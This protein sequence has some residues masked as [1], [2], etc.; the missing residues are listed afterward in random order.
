MDQKNLGMA[1]RLKTVQSKEPKR[2]RKVKTIDDLKEDINSKCL[3][4]KSIID[5]GNLKK[6]RELEP[7]VSKAMADELGFN[8]GRFSEK[9]RNPIMFSMKEIHHF[10]YYVGVDAGKITD[11]IN[12]EIKG[13]GPIVTK[14]KKFKSIGDFKQYKPQA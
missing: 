5:S 6:L 3:S 7:L 4:I 13:N 10:G 12:L 14:L 9:L 11:Q 1:K 8:H 2:G